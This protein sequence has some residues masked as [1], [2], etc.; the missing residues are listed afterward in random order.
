MDVMQIDYHTTPFRA[1]RF[2]ALYE[3]AAGRVLAYGAKEYVLFRDEEDPDHFVH[4]SFWEDRSAFDRY[5]FSRDMQEVRQQITGLYG[6]P[7]L[8]HWGVVVARG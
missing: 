7:V 8:P 3:P 2:L 6:Q 4:L 1:A 5:W